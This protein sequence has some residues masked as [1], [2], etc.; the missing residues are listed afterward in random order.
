MSF[1]EKWW[2]Y[3]FI[4]ESY[5]GSFRYFVIGRLELTPRRTEILNNEIRIFMKEKGIKR[6]LKW[7]SISSRNADLHVQ[8]LEIFFNSPTLNYEA[9]VFDTMESTW[10]KWINEG[11]LKNALAKAYYFAIAGLPIGAST[12]FVYFTILMVLRKKFTI[13]TSILGLLTLL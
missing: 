1:R 13:S 9:I 7:K 10:N 2:K 12:D 6:E 5:M 11:G 4:D 3:V 8:F